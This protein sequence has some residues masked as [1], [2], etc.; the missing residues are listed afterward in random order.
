MIKLTLLNDIE[1]LINPDQI[2]KIETNATSILILKDGQKIEV[3]ESG[4][5]ISEII[6]DLSFRNKNFT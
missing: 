6:K 1:I 5:K 3:K 4:A 2:D